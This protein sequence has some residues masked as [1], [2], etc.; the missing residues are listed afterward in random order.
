MPGTFVSRRVDQ[1]VHFQD[2]SGGPPVDAK[3]ESARLLVSDTGVRELVLVVWVDYWTYKRID[4]G[5][6][7]GYTFESIDRDGFGGWEL[8]SET[9]VQ[10]EL[11]AEGG[12]LAAVADHDGEAVLD[13]ALAGLLGDDT[14]SPWRDVASYRYL[15]MYQEKGAGAATYLSGFTS[16]YRQ[17]A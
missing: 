1:P 17:R 13:L 4:R 15:A 6:L 14:T 12:A 8:T 7:F 9:L 3:L 2:R 10:I 5:H 11:R 16:V